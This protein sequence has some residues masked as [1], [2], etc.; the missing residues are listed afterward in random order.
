MTQIK[1]KTVLITG[2]ASGIGKIMAEKM[3]V[4]GASTVII[5]DINEQA[6]RQLAQELSDKRLIFNHVDVSKQESISAASS[7]LI[8]SLLIPD[9]LIL[10]AGIVTGKYFQDHQS[11]E[12]LQ[13]ININVL[14]CLLTAN[15]FL[16]KMIERKSGHIITIAS[17]AGMM[18]VPKMSVYVAS[19]WA[20]LGWSESLRLE[21]KSLQTGIE[22]T[23][24]TPSYID[25]GMF[26]GAKVNF[27]LPN[28][29]PEIAVNKIIYGIENNKKFVRMPVLVYLIPFFKGILPTTWFDLIV[30][31]GLRVYASMSGFKGR[32]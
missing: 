28:M 5:W 25:T 4:K 27:L 29:K 26:A 7:Q 24:V 16:P 21:M 31:K 9:I 15:A 23:S 18:A 19:K 32:K 12:I 17:A 10:N 8:A 1:N 3:L 14:G 13:S 30:G 20:V 11:S 22:I 6:M 2:G